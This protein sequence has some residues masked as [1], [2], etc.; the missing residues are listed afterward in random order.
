MTT[1]TSLQAGQVP[2]P[3]AR[4]LRRL[5]RR[6]RAVILV[7]GLAAVVATAVGAILAVMA[8]DAGFTLFSQASRWALTL[9]AMAATAGVAVRFLV[10]PLAH[11]ITLTGI[12]RAI[13]TRHPEL[14]E[15]LSSAVELLTSR[16]IPEVRGSEALISALAD[17]AT[18]DAARVQPRTEVP[19]RR[20]RPFLLAAGGVLV[21]LGALWAL[22]PT[23]LPRLLT[24]AVAPFVNLPNVSAD[25][26]V[27]RPGDTILAEGQR[28]EVRVTV[29]NPAV[30]RCSLRREMPDGAEQPQY[31]TALPPTDEDHPRFTMTLPPAVATF[32]Y[33][34]HAG[35]ALSRF[36]NV[37]VVPPPVV[38]QIDA[39]FAYPA[40]A[41]L[42]AETRTDIPGDIK[43]LAGTAVTVTATLNKPVTGAVLRIDGREAEQIP[44]R[45][46]TD[47]AGAATCEFTVHL[48]PQTRGRWALAMQD[49]HGF[50]NTS[51]E[52]ALQALPDTPP[53]VEILDPQD[54]RSTRPTGSP[55]STR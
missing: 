6:V 45:I 47:P 27:V 22:F 52:H 11:T 29:A 33:R 24:R 34:V 21:I 23:I 35:D 2:D 43:A 18:R 16:D 25:M 12:A 38:K 41:G 54:N 37:T 20:A 50:T 3:I 49:E 39:H 14:Q 31:M 40:Y 55:S 32:R 13:E 4:A 19:L 15:R 8:I 51:A 10:L 48:K 7:R 30:K 46:A 9:V 17:E 1:H 26:L 44:V 36:Y 42:P 53:T 28:L 5:I